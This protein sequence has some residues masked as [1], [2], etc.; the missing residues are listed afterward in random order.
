MPAPGH[1]HGWK[2]IVPAA[3]ALDPGGNSLPDRHGRG[4]S[5]DLSR[6]LRT[7]ECQRCAQGLQ[8]RRREILAY[9]DLRH[10][11]FLPCSIGIVYH[12]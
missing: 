7:G 1:Q 6:C 2:T 8:A 9:V 12:Q 11:A 3:A 10:G 4:A 5:Q